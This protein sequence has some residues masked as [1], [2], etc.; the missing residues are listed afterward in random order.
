VRRSFRLLILFASLFAA[1][2]IL[3]PGRGGSHAQ[4]PTW[5]LFPVPPV[6]SLYAVDL[7]GPNAGW[8]GGMAGSMLRWDGSTWSAEWLTLDT[9]VMAIDVWDARNAWAATYNGQI[10][11]YDG[12]SWQVAAQPATEGYLTDI[13]MLGP[14]EGWA[15][16]HAGKI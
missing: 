9:A 1:G 4:S 7:A 10:L 5:Q 11:H 12:G 3:P 14:D 16:G 15:V 6:G 8:A 13:Y 2:L